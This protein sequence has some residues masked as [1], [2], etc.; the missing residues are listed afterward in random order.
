MIKKFYLQ[1]P[2]LNIG[3]PSSPILAEIVM[4]WVEECIFQNLPVKPKFYLRY[5]DDVFLQMQ[6]GEQV[7]DFFDMITS[8]VPFLT[9]TVTEVQNASLDFLDVKILF[10]DNEIQTTVYRKPMYKPL[11]LKNNS[12]NSEAHKV[13]AIYSA[14]IRAQTHCSTTRLKEEELETILKFSQ[15][16]GFSKRLEIGRAHV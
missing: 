15:Q 4:T 8:K 9:F 5:V 7:K 3:A 1:G 14:L 2:G 13:S 16:H 12:Y 10:V 6:D 11:W